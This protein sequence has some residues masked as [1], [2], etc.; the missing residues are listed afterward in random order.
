MTNEAADTLRNALSDDAENRRQRV[1]TYLDVNAAR[2]RTTGRWLS[3]VGFYTEVPFAYAEA[4]ASSSHPTDNP[5]GREILRVLLVPYG[6]DRDARRL[7]SE[8]AQDRVVRTARVAGATGL[9]EYPGA[10]DFLGCAD[11]EDD[12]SCPQKTQ[13]LLTAMQRRN[14]KA[15]HAFITRTGA[16]YVSVPL[17]AAVAPVADADDAVCIGIESACRKPRAGGAVEEAPW[18]TEQLASLAVL[19][20]KIKSAYPVIAEGNVQY[21]VRSDNPL[22]WFTSDADAASQLAAAVAF[23][24]TYD[25]STEVFLRSPPSSSH[26]GSAQAA[27]QSREH[28]DTIGAT[29]ALLGAYVDLAAMDRSSNMQAAERSRVFVQR[30][31]VSHTEGDEG[32]SAAADAAGAEMLIPVIPTVAQVGPHVFNYATGLWGDGSVT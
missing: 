17:D 32:A 4:H 19:I 28:V 18:T 20:A 21:G 24:G 7:N 23:E 1:G 2:R 9:S 3:E 30:A 29:S 22:P 11:L 15:V 27:L 6:R 16:V 5:D 14:G 26:R 8:A 25:P 12:T 13:T 10:P 31:R